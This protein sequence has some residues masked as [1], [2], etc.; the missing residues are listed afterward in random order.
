MMSSRPHWTLWWASVAHFLNDG[1][2]A[3]LTPLLPLMATDL[4]LSYSQAGTV[5]AALN[6]LTSLSQLPAGFLATR[7]G[8]AA[9]LGLGLGWFSLSFL[10]MGLAGGYLALLLLMASAGI[11]AGVYHPVGTAWVSRAFLGRRRGAAVGTLNFSGDVGK[12]VLPALAGALITW[13]G[14]RDSLAALGVAGAVAAAALI[15]WD[16]LARGDTE[17]ERAP[18]ANKATSWGIAQRGQF[19]LISVVGLIDQAGRSGVMAFLGFLLLAKGLPQAAMGWLVAVTFAGG[20]LGKFGCGLL[21]D[22]FEDRRVMAVTEVTMA[23]GCL[24]LA[25]TNPGPFLVPLLLA[26]GFALNGTSSVIYTRLA[27]SLQPESFSRGYGLYYS[28]SFAAS[29]VS[30]V[31]YGLLADWRGLVWVYVTIAAMNLC[32]LPL[33]ALLKGTTGTVAAAPD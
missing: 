3:A 18:E 13:I 2:A 19:A 28:L 7:A 33:L 10:F 6:G 25:F 8:E 26:F 30:P 17:T 23:A 5:K 27:D 31:L 21:T 12:V 14:W 9:F 20:A 11:G 16:W 4:A 29:A 32:I 22:R 15:A 1:L 24:M